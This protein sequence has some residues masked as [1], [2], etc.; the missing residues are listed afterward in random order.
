MLGYFQIDNTGYIANVPVCAEYCDAWFEAC[1]NDMT[2]VE[3]WLND[4][5]YEYGNNTC[6]NGSMCVTF[7]EMYRNGEGLCNRMWGDAFFYETSDNC[8]VMSFNPNEENPNFELQLPVSA[9]EIQCATR[10]LIWL[11]VVMLATAHLAIW[12]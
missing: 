11:L 1:R 5:N 4:Y 8:T 2:C 10:C 6:P 3:D 9:A 7:E 12:E